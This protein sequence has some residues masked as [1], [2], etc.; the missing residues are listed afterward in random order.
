MNTSLQIPNSAQHNVLNCSSS[1]DPSG[2]VYHQNATENGPHTGTFLVQC[3]HCSPL[4]VLQLVSAPPLLVGCTPPACSHLPP[5]KAQAWCL[6]PKVI[7]LSY[8]CSSFTLTV[9]FDCCCSCN[10]LEIS[11]S[12]CC[13][14]S[15]L[16]LISTPG[17]CRSCCHPLSGILTTEE[18]F[19]LLDAW[20]PS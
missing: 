4:E 15:Y 8:C 14:C 1:S 5:P 9:I 12:C 20:R 11:L 10:P 6:W 19:G 17:C 18:E 7:C 16:P 3:W 13:Y 2:V